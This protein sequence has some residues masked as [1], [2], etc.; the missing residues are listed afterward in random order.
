[1]NQLFTDH[2]IELGFAD[3]R[4]A[5]L[6]EAIGILHS[7]IGYMDL[8]NRALFKSKFPDAMELVS[9]YGDCSYLCDNYR[10]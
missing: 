9:I 4:A 5:S 2:L 8:N 1:M 3:T 6:N 10:D 7:S